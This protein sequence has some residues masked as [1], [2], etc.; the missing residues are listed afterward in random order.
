MK[1]INKFYAILLAL[2]TFAC[3]DAID[4]EQPGL[5]L[6][7]NAFQS[8]DDLQAGLY[9][10]YNGFDYTGEILF[11]GIYTDELALGLNNGGQNASEYDLV[12]TPASVF[13]VVI[14]TKYYIA[15]ANVNRLIEASGS[16]QP[17]D[18][19][20]DT[21]NLILGQAYA[22]RAFAHFQLQTYYTTDY[23]DDSAMGVIALNY[24]PEIGEQLSRNTNGEVFSFIESDLVLANNLLDNSSTDPTFINKDFV[25]ALS[26]RMAAYRGNYTVAATLASELLADYPIASSADYFN[27]WEDTSNAE[28]IFKL[29]RTANDSYD[30]Q[31]TGSGGTAGSLFAFANSTI[32]GSPYMEMDRHLFN[33]LSTADIRSSRYIDPTSVISPDY[34]N[35]LDYKS[36][37]ILVIRKYPGSETVNLM[38]DL[39]V[40]RSAEML[41]IMAEAAA[42]NNQLV[43]VATLIKQL[44][45]ARF[46]SAQPLP[47]YATQTEAFGA[48]LD[49]R[50]LE[51]AYEGH[52]WVDIK[53][54]G[55]KGNRTLDREPLDCAL[56]NAV[57]CSMPNTDKRFTMP[58]PLNEIDINPLLAQ[59]PGY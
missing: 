8:V 59:N 14:W 9:G 6:S 54:L 45:D 44:R 10:A 43:D 15:L 7:E 22:L 26:A 19:E 51:L 50:R 18:G 27:I 56:A 24:V 3:N 25:K 35:S 52:R 39:K 1:K 28:I 41:F 34:Q 17:E 47:V 16:I 57:E 53:R 48:I 38:N 4:I 12:L 2:I 13:P 40:F 5:L 11:N 32:D 58:I 23:T 55:A 21:Y 30:A 37:D 29:E 46:G 36:E 20:L 42:E 31:E 33:E 49:E